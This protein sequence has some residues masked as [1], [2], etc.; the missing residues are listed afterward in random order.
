[1]YQ[2]TIK[3][4]ISCEHIQVNIYPIRARGKLYHHKVIGIND[5]RDNEV[6]TDN[7]MGL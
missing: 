1:M 2:P 4:T 6:W 5:I 7:G 3:D